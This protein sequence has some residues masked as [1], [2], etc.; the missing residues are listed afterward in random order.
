MLRRQPVGTVFEKGFGRPLVCFGGVI[1]RYV[2]TLLRT[3]DILIK[4]AAAEVGY[5]DPL[6]FLRVFRQSFGIPPEKVRGGAAGCLDT[7]FAPNIT[8]GK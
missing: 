3:N 4:R 2:G 8:A 5:R 6:H 7:F 1:M